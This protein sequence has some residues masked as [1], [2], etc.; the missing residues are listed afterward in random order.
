VDT[1][2]FPRSRYQ[3][4]H[5]DLEKYAGQYIAWCPDGTTI[6]ASN[7][8]PLRLIA[9]IHAAGYDHEQT[10]IEAIPLP[11]EV[12]LGDGLLRCEETGG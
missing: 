11:D 5:A 7:A 9:E 2:A 10:L 4:P 12:I 8:D 6:I 1:S 3:F